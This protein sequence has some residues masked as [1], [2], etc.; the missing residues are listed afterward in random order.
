[1]HTDGNPLECRTQAEKEISMK[2]HII[3]TM[4]GAL[5]LIGSVSSAAW[6]TDGPPGP[7]H[8]M[9]PP[10]EA[11]EACKDKTEGIA[12]EFTNR[13]GETVKATCT[14]L[15]DRLVAVPEGWAGGRRGTQ[16]AK[17]QSGE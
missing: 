12:V 5:F 1:M 13:R 17:T 8:H 6:A 10:P 16:P 9:G 14:Q 7:G 4:V 2:K 11:I 3:G 15:H